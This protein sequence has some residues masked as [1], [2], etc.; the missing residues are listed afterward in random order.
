MSSENRMTARAEQYPSG[1][2][3]GG[4]PQLDLGRLQRQHPEAHLT[5]TNAVQHDTQR[6]IIHALVHGLGDATYNEIRELST[7]GDRT[8]R[9][10]VAR[11]EDAGI[12]RREQSWIGLVTVAGEDV[13]RLMEHALDCYY[14]TSP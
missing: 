12:V 5:V 3:R 2:T 9:K 11:L 8:I 1:N 4:V 13:L 7:V 6:R 10:H 14:N